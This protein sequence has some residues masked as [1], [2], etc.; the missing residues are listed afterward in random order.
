MSNE[1]ISMVC[2]VLLGISNQDKDIR[3]NSVNKLQELSNNLGALTFCLIEIASKTATNDKE[4]TVKTTALV[5][6]RKI[7]DTKSYEC[8][9]KI[10]NNLKDKIKISALN[11]LN[12]ETDPSQNSKVCDLIVVIMEKVLDCDEEWPQR[13]SL[14]L[15][16]DNYD[17]ND[18]SKIIQIR[19][20]LKL[21][22][23]GTGYMYKYISENY[24][25]LI[26]Y[27]EK[28]FD[29]GID[30]KIKALAAEFICELVKNNIISV[31]LANNR[32]NSI[33]INIY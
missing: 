13:F 17:P 31:K 7:L 21:L 19:T 25:K 10:D 33:K 29:S 4:K 27:L 15:S 16:L 9:K 3:T 23:E 28:L 22:T 8:W 20:L 32:K 11:L 5:I 14:A 2:D 6:C 18:N 26:P 30:M 24:K 12:S 1:D